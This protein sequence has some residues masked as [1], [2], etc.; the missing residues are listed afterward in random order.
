MKTKIT[1]TMF[2]DRKRG[3]AE[4]RRFVIPMSVVGDTV[5]CVSWYEGDGTPS[6]TKINAAR[7]E[8]PKSFKQL[9]ASEL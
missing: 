2:I 6:F 8:S 4:K 5:N 7:F 3:T 9:D 1:G